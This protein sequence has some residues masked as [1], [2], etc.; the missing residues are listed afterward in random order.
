MPTWP[1]KSKPL[2]LFRIPVR[3][4]LRHQFVTVLVIRN[5]FCWA[6][7]DNTRA[8]EYHIEREGSSD[9]IHSS[10]LAI[11]NDQ[12][13]ILFYFSISPFRISWPR[14]DSIRRWSW[15]SHPSCDR[16]RSMFFCFTS[17]QVTGS[18]RRC[19]LEWRPP[20]DF[21]R[22]SAMEIGGLNEESIIV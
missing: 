13:L 19:R 17:R 11:G 6:G 21:L 3:L 1:C 2:F 20:L 5:L 15:I 14:F 9:P 8:H 10:T 16:F 7:R 18:R 4:R 12:N 22:N